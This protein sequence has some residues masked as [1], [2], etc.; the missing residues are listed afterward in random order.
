[1]AKDLA[2]AAKID[3]AKKSPAATAADT[4]VATT[5][6]D[7]DRTSKASD[8]EATAPERE[9]AR[10]IATAGPKDERATGI[11]KAEQPVI[12]VPEDA[13][14]SRGYFKWTDNSGQFRKI[15]IDGTNAIRTPAHEQHELTVEDRDRLYEAAALKT[16][17]NGEPDV[18][19]LEER[20]PDA[21]HEQL[22]GRGVE[23]A[24]AEEGDI[25][26]GKGFDNA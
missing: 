13:I 2:T 25:D 3:A 1:M 8:T 16:P 6:V 23:A 20:A 4:T 12:D 15:P 21:P 18:A 9:I 22:A 10:Q 24:A 5:S 11:L 19:E 17:R 7:T 26:D 14:L